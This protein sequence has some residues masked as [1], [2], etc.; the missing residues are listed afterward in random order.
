MN[1]LS[2]L[3]KTDLIYALLIA[4]FI[5]LLALLA[6]FG[7]P[8]ASMVLP[9][10]VGSAAGYGAA[11]LTSS[12]QAPAW[13]RA[14]GVTSAAIGLI[15]VFLSV[16]WPFTNSGLA[17]DLLNFDILGSGTPLERLAFGFSV[18]YFGE[19][20]RRISFPAFFPQTPEE[21]DRRTREKARGAL[22]VGGIFLGFIVLISI[23][24]GALA[25]IAYLVALFYG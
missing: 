3:S 12:N 16:L 4:V 11:R 24:F 9:F 7:H 6:L 23:V 18:V 25:L 22:I 20:F 13:A 14:V 8:L 21:A 17:R 1:G 5:F 15:W 2:G 19:T 10:V